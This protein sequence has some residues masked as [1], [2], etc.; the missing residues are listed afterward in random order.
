MVDLADFEALA[1][2]T[3]SL[4]VALHERDPYTRLHCDRVDLMACE[5]GVV[6]GVSETDMAILRISSIMHDV[7]KI[8]I[9]D[10]ILLKPASLEPDEWKI[11]K[12]H[13]ARGQRIVCATLLPNAPE[14]GAVLRHHHEYFN[15][16]G[17]PDGLAGEDIPL[18]SRILSIADSY[19]AMATP[20]IYHCARTHDEIM[21]VLHSEVGIKSDPWVFA[22]FVQV[23]DRSPYRVP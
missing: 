6:C 8:G 17:Y 5:L 20:R 7:G 14:I 21:E 16:T 9:P 12:T 13:S 4:S 10:S 1:R 23:I 18:P 2:F 19:D 3:K 11:I 22:Q 15:G